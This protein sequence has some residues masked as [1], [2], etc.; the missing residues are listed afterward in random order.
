MN[1]KIEKSMAYGRVDAPPSKSMAHRL[2]ICAGLAQGESVLH[3]ISLSEDIRATLDCLKS[4]GAEYT[5]SDGTIRMT[6]TRTGLVDLFEMDCHESGSTLRFFI[7]ICLLTGKKSVFHGTE[8]LLSRPLGV[9]RELCEMQ[10]I[11]YQH[12]EDSLIVK[13]KISSGEFQIPGNISSQFISGLLFAL[14]LLEGDSLITIKPPVESR[15]Y[16]NLTIKALADFGVKVIWQSETSLFIRGGQVYQP[17]EAFVEGDYS[18]A[19]FLEVFNYLG[20]N[21]A[22]N[23]LDENS[24]Q[25]DKIYRRMFRALE[26]TV[27]VLDLS[28]C[29]DLAPI[30]FTLAVI[31]NG[32]KFIG[33]KRLKIKESDR[34][35]VMAKELAK[36]GADVQVSEDSVLIRQTKLHKPDEMLSGNNDHRVVMSLAV[37]STLFGGEIEGAEAVKKSFPDFFEKLILLNIKVKSN[38]NRKE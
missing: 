33:T 34:A 23:G 7:P 12:T 13:G 10:G 5:Y 26:N 24:L 21:V 8:K 17:Q 35:N 15:S 32:A 20:G 29:P 11:A 1:I 31:K 16:I 19:A 30:L 36:F 3:N 28:D 27:P 6:G 2:L 37:L 22:I 9:Y 18:N 14:P 4:L 25:G 38:E